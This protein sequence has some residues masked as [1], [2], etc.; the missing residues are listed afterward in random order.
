[1]IGLCRIH[2]PTILFTY[3]NRCV[4]TTYNISCTVVMLKTLFERRLNYDAN[5]NQTSINIFFYK[6]KHKNT[7]HDS[8]LL[9][10]LI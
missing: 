6:Q 2:N 8:E 7:K 9:Y 10:K 3:I 5:I 1:M 4:Y